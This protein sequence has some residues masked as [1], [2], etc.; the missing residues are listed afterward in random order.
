MIKTIINAIKVNFECHASYGLKNPT[1]CVAS[2]KCTSWVAEM[3]AFQSLI[4]SLLLFVYSTSMHSVRASEVLSSDRI[5]VAY[6]NE[7]MMRCRK[8][9]I[10]KGPTRGT[11]VCLCSADTGFTVQIIYSGHWRWCPRFIDYNYKT[12]TWR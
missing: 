2:C 3:K 1:N 9:P 6:G 10:G 5:V 11:L 8:D 7:V 4:A 12:N